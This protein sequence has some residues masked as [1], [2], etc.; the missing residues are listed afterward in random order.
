MELLITIAVFGL[1]GGLVYA[2]VAPRA[3]SVDETIQQRLE[4]LSASAQARSTARILLYETGEE[5]PWERVFKFF[6]GDRELPE[7][8]TRASRMLHQAGFRGTR[9]VRIFWGLRISLCLGLGFGLLVLAMISSSSMQ[10]LVMMVAAGALVGYMLPYITVL[11][12]AKAR[13]LEMRESLPDTLDLLVVCVEAGM[14][15]D[16]AINRVGREQH[17]QKISLGAELVLTSQEMQAG[18]PR[19]EALSRMADRCGIEELQ[20]LVTFLAQTE[21]VGG[22]ISRSLRVFAETMRDKRSQAAEEAARKA[23][24]KL[25]FP[26]V[27]FILPV[28]FILVLGPPALQI[29]KI[30]SN[31]LG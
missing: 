28:I 1:V 15:V 18:A 25:I 7:R 20:T 16:A 30:L 29:M 23:V 22:S 6:F 10:D 17:E 9:S 14:G 24:I 19:R 21:E 27:F 13:V 5:T 11:R 12:K 4:N 8:F 3:A 31:P 2:V 26:L